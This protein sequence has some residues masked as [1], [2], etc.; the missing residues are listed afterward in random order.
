MA[1][2]DI[3]PNFGA[4]LKVSGQVRGSCALLMRHA[5]RMPSSPSVPGWAT[6]SH[7]SKIYSNSIGRGA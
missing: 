6:V 5:V 2:V 1:D 4:E 7:G 3:A